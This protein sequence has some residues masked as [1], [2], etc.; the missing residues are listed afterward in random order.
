LPFAVPTDEAHLAAFDPDAIDVTYDLFHGQWLLDRD[1]RAAAFPFGSGLTYTT[2]ALADARVDAAPATPASG[3]NEPAAGSNEAGGW[4][5][6]ASVRVRNSGGRAGSTVVQVYG[7][8][9]GSSHERPDRRLLGFRRVTLGAGEEQR[10]E[11]AVT[12]DPLRVRQAGVWYHEPGTYALDVGLQAH[13]PGR[14]AL[15]LEA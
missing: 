11:I 4:A 9:P 7:G 8:L 2:F 10:V 5:G 3:P 1:D 6:R 14:L 12:L 15:T 13:D